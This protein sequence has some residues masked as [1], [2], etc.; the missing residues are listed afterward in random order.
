M[1]SNYFTFSTIQNKHHFV[2]RFKSVELGKHHFY[3]N[4]QTYPTSLMMDGFNIG[5]YFYYEVVKHLKQENL[6]RNNEKST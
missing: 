4:K 2:H 3:K 5:D 1:Y 6:N